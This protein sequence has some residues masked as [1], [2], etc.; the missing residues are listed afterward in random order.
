MSKTKF[1]RVPA[2]VLAITMMIAAVPSTAADDE[3]LYRDA[4]N[5]I[6]TRNITTA[7]VISGTFIINGSCK[8]QLE[9]EN[10]S[11]IFN[12]ID[13]DNVKFVE[14]KVKNGTRVKRG[15]VIAQVSV[16][17]EDLEYDKLAIQL[18]TEEANYEQ[19]ID[20]NKGLL[21][22]YE[23]RIE[24]AATADERETAQL[25][26]DRLTVSFEEEKKRRDSEIENLRNTVNGYYENNG[27]EY[28]TAPIDGVVSGLNRF[29]SGDKLGFYTYIGAVYDTDSVRVRV[30]GGSQLAFNMPVTIVQSSAGSSV[31]VEG[32]VTSNNNAT[33]AP[34]LIGSTDN[35]E[36]LGD[37]SVLD[38][39]GDIS[40][41]FQTVTMENAVMVPRKA[42]S[43]DTGGDYVFR[44]ENGMSVK[45]YIL[46]GGI[47]P[48]Y[49]W[50]VDGL[51]EGDEVVIK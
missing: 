27:T 4:V 42:V 22:D 7:Q 34:N 39:N 31:S 37:P 48:D 30:Y 16:E 44:Y 10:V 25:L 14:F 28:I 29:R 46:A 21:R 13:S 49:V 11:Y 1:L 47:N 5:N 35:V 43:S 12:D 20:V 15:D 50:V 9:C 18:A 17:V 33:L 51:N 24:H 40:L 6:V 45:H 2:L 36:I 19:Y 38:I 41:R 8:A 3:E 26:Y 23:Y 32:R